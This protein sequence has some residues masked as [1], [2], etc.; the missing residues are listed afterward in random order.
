[1]Q[2]VFDTRPIGWG[3]C[4]AIVASGIAILV[5]AEVEKRVVARIVARLRRRPGS[6]VG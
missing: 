5:V 4:V 2:A 1:M 6:Q 3:A